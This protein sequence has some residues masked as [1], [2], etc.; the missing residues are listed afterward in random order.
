MRLDSKT[1]DCCFTFVLIPQPLLKE[2]VICSILSNERVM[3]AITHEDDFVSRA[4]R[5]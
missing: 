2:Y 1:F 3:M 5:E 4:E